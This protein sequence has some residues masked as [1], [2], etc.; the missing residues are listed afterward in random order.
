MKA[1]NGMG[2]NAIYAWVE[3]PRPQLSKKLW[4]AMYAEFMRNGQR[5]LTRGKLRYLRRLI[6]R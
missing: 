1:R 6:R 4:L 5:M 2:G 3:Q